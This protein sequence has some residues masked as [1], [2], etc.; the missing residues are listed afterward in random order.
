M[1]GTIIYEVG[2]IICDIDTINV[3]FYLLEVRY[4]HGYCR[5]TQYQRSFINSFELLKI[6][7]SFIN[8]YRPSCYPNI[9]LRGGVI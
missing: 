8:S 6:N 4:P 5:I 2:T 1:V 3:R 7:K 9:N